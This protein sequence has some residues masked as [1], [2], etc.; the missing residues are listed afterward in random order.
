MTVQ[1]LATYVPEAAVKGCYNL[2]QQYKV[3]LKVVRKRMTRHGDYRKYPDGTHRITVNASS[4]PYRFL[5]T[6][7]HEIAHLVAFEAHGRR[8]RPHGTEWKRT[9]TL[10]MAPFIRP[11]IWP[12]T[13]LPLLAHHFKNPKASSSTDLRLALE[14][15][16]YDPPTG[17][18]MVSELE[19]GTHFKLYNGKVF[20]KGKQRVKRIECLEIKSGKVYLFQ[21]HAEVERMH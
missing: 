2:L 14:L 20:R 16:K 6:L 15:K 7:I 4:N 9:F 5:L 3:Q 18:Q 19:V 11:E 1:T 8:I 10:L 21:P 13:M 17:K 12:V